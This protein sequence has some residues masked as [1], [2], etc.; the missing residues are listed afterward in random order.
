MGAYDDDGGNDG[1][2][3][4]GGHNQNEAK[5][6]FVGFLWLGPID[7]MKCFQRANVKEK[8]GEQELTEIVPSCLA[9]ADCN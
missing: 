9:L 2:A 7:L 1:V 4:H 5:L 8:S 6:I 3:E